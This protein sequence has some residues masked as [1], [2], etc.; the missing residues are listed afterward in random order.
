M[1]ISKIILMSPS[2]VRRV[3]RDIGSKSTVT[4]SNIMLGFMRTLD[5][6]VRWRNDMPA[7]R[8]CV[9]YRKILMKQAG[10]DERC[11]GIKPKLTPAVAS[12]RRRVAC[13]KVVHP[14][15]VVAG[16]CNIGWGGKEIVRTRYQVLVRAQ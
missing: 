2:E 8:D 9:A 10:D 5:G 12:C 3:L 13:K 11:S 1:Q 15:K 7:A 6:N 4:G 14:G 16:K